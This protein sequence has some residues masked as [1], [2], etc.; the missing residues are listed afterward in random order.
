MN[1]THTHTPC[2]VWYKNLSDRPL[3]CLAA[4]DDPSSIKLLR[5]S[6]YPP[7]GGLNTQALA[8]VAQADWV[9]DVNMIFASLVVISKI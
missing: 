4:K 6:L 2:H 8:K 1:D 5:D 3:P 7:S 9:G